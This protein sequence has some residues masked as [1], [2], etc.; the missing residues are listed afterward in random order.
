MNYDA[1]IDTD[2]EPGSSVGSASG[3]LMEDNR[4]VSRKMLIVGAIILA[5]LI[6]LWFI[7]RFNK[8][9]ELG[10]ADQAQAPVVTVIVPG[11]GSVAGEISTTGTLAARRELPVG[12]VGDGGR[13]ERVFV[14]PGDWVRAGQVLAVIDRSV[15]NEEA[16]S[17]DAQIAVA[18]ANARLAQANLDRALRLVDRGF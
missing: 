16:A 10:A 7:N 8:P 3:E 11:R 15:Q 4:L 2:R 1:K 5:V 6:G 18:Q 9:D 17:L 14:E 13:V 12:S